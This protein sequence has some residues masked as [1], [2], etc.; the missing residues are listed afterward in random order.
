MVCGLATQFGIGASLHDGEER[1][2]V[3]VERL[4]FAEVLPSAFQPALCE[5]EG[6][7]RIVEV[8]VARR[9][10]VKGHHYVRTDDALCVYDVFRGEQ[11]ART[12]Y[13]AAEMSS[14]LR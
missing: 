1:L 14:F 7:A 11:V 13:V 8:G 10:F 4:C 3:A 6:T 12:V 2:A 5:T 9:A